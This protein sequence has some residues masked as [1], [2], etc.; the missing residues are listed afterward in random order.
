MKISVLG[1]LAVIVVWA[2]VIPA[3]AGDLKQSEVRTLGSG[4]VEV[5]SGACVGLK[6]NSFQHAAIRC[7]CL[8]KFPYARVSSSGNV[9]L[10]GQK[11]PPAEW[12]ACVGG[13]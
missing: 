9:S 10:G 12:T 5:I 3:A 13:N 8:Q 2:G 1:S 4:G 6:G 11:I 7:K